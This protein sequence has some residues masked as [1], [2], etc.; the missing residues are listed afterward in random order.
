MRERSFGKRVL[1]VDDSHAALSQ[2]VSQLL[3]GIEVIGVRQ[4]TLNCLIIQMRAPTDCFSDFSLK[5][6]CEGIE[7]RRQGNGIAMSKNI[8]AR[9]IMGR[10]NQKMCYRKS[11]RK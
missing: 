2:E 7:N 4:N 9:N 1:V 5:D 10:R 11:G 8:R 3:K 6:V